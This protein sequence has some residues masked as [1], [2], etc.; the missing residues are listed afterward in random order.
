VSDEK[1]EA[2]AEVV[3]EALGR[4]ALDVTIKGFTDQQKAM[5]VLPDPSRAEAFVRPIVETAIKKQEE[6]AARPFIPV[7]HGFEQAPTKIGIEDVGP[8]RVVLQR[9]AKETRALKKAAKPRT[10]YDR[11]LFRRLDELVQYPEW[12]ARIMKATMEGEHRAMTSGSDLDR[13][14]P[15]RRLNSIADALIKI[16][17]DSI[18]IFGSFLHPKR[19]GPLIMVGPKET[20]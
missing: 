9:T 11:M 15:H 16:A 2:P 8:D 10:R 3:P 6:L 4:E 5:G 20:P 1:P 12:R 7:R 14:D 17:E 13:N 19:K 18:P